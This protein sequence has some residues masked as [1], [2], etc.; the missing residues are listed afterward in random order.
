MR[1]NET[2]AELYTLCARGVFASWNTDSGELVSCTQLD[3][4]KGKASLAVIDP[5]KIVVYIPELRQFRVFNAESKQMVS[6]FPQQVANSPPR[7][8][9]SS[10]DSSHTVAYTQN[11]T[12]VIVDLARRSVDDESQ[13]L[14]TSVK[15]EARLTALEVARDGS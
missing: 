11:R 14:Q 7:H 3:Y 12:L 10:F 8:L 6:W 9:A 2:E 5:S 15:R 4:G 13:P 1:L